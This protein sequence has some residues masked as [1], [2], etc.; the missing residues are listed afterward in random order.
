MSEPADKR[1][2]LL[3]KVGDDNGPLNTSTWEFQNVHDIGDD[4][5]S[6]GPCVNGALWRGFRLM[7]EAEIKRQD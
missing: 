6:P 2:N 4:I 1:Q 3:E 5:L 7:F